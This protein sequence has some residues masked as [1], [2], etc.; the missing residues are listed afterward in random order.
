MDLNLVKTNEATNKGMNIFL[1]LSDVSG[2]WVAYGQ[3]AYALRLYVKAQ[4][5]DSLRAYSAELNMPCT[6]ISHKTAKS[7][8]HELKIVDEQGNNQIT[9]EAK[10][11]FE[12]EKYLM[13]MEKLHKESEIGEHTISVQTLV[14]DKVPRGVFIPDGMSD[15]TRSLKRMFDC[16]AAGVSLLVF[17]PLF[18]VCYVAIKMD[19][20]GPAI[21]AQERIG[22]FGRTFRIFKFRSMRMDSEKNGPQLSAQQGE[23]DNRLTKVGRFIRAHH[24]DELPQLWNVF[25]GDMSF[26]GPRPERK[27][28]IDQIMEYDKRYTYL[29]QIR[30]GVTS[31]AT[32]YNGYT[33]TMEKMLKRLEYDLYYLKKRSWLFDIKILTKTFLSII[34]G[35]K[36]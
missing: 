26:V 18:A 14:S 8:R 29:Y 2:Q 23:G 28:F 21:Y 32:L 22:R 6:V 17:S 12:F 30:P 36:F 27:F 19:D 35:K 15:L 3:S 7:L 11:E 25:C 24:L 16:L 10:E 34:F 20:G 5:Y 31:Y 33:D 9:F 13:W 1:Y 4:E